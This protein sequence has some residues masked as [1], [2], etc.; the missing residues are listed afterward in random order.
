MIMRIAVKKNFYQDSVK[1]MQMTNLIKAMP[2]VITAAAIM[3]TD[4]NKATISRAGFDLEQ[5]NQ[6]GSNDIL[7]LVKGE[8]EAFVVAAIAN[9]Q[10]A[11]DEH[12]TSSK[13]DTP[14]PRSVSSAGLAL[15]GSNFALISVP[16]EYAAYE[17]FKALRAGMNV[18]IFSDNVPVEQEIK[19]KKLGQRLGLLVMGPDCGTSIIGG[20]PLGFANV[21]AS[22]P[23]GIVGASGTGIQQLSVLIDRLGSGISH[24]IGLGGRDLSDAVGGISAIMALDILEDDDQTKVIVMVSKPPGIQTGKKIIEKVRASSK[25]VVLVFLGGDRNFLND[26][27]YVA[28]NLEQGAA[29]AVALAAGKEANSDILAFSRDGIEDILVKETDDKDSNRKYLRGLFCGGSLADEALIGLKEYISPVVSNIHPDPALKMADVNKSLGHTIIDMGDDEF[30]KGRPHPMID[31]FYRVERLLAEWADPQVAVILCDV[32]L[33]YGSHT[34]P[35]G[36]LADAVKKARA[37]YGG[38]VTVV[39]SVCGTEKDPQVL[40]AQEDLLKESGVLVYPT[41]AFATQIAGEIA[42]ISFERSAKYGR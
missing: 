4:N 35:A 3:G 27:K 18:Q 33:G 39:A 28:A 41:N 22:G 10:S 11:L 30:T 36:A 32:V 2:G 29:M 40:S 42:R 25:P 21:V 9:Y 12:I 31:P 38:G 14:A 13:T 26:Q 17:A 20:V 8:D 15:S 16:G 23:V 5:M 19:L 7:F 6:A 1:L 34:N 24:A 37:Q